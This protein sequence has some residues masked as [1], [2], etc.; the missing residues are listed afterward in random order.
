MTRFLDGPAVE[1]KMLLLKR[2]PHFLRVVQGPNGDWDALDQLDDRPSADEKVFAYEMVG[3]PTFC[4]IR[5]DKRAGGSGLYRGGTYRI[6]AEQP[7]DEQMRSTALWRD[8]C[9]ARIGK[10]LAEDGTV[11]EAPL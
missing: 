1:S 3:E 11:Q 4:H 6:V 9:S 7:T 10:P 2:A 8:W 5:R